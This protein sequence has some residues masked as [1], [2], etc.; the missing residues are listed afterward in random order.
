MVSGIF[1]C[2][3][4]KRQERQEREARSQ[5]ASTLTA[6][7][8]GRASS[9][10]SS[11]HRDERSSQSSRV[12]CLPT[13][14][15]FVIQRPAASA[16]APAPAQP[17]SR[18]CFGR[19]L[20]CPALI[21]VHQFAGTLAA[22]VFLSRG[23]SSALQKHGRAVLA[24]ALL[25]RLMSGLQYAQCGLHAFACV[26][27][28]GGCRFQGGANVAQGSTCCQPSPTPTH[29]CARMS[30]QSTKARRW[31][32][33]I[34][35]SHPMVA[36]LWVTLKPQQ[37]LALSLHQVAATAGQAQLH[38]VCR[39]RCSPAQQTAAAASVT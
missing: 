14:V 33:P 39:A 28:R 8:D 20:R 24:H 4:I 25:S 9:A 32:T 21:H 26:S 16:Q 29:G 12:R 31:R 35:L 38:Q 11:S 18:R 27:Q 1:F 36:T 5:A 37:L 3:C 7:T 15:L 2:S 23:C 22:C 19:P 6:G 10:A 30:C 34:R 13:S 17:G